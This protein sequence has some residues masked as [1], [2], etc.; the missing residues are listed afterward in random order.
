MK[1]WIGHILEEPE[2]WFLVWAETEA[3]ALLMVD[4]TYGEPDVRSLLEIDLPGCLSLLVEQTEEF[5]GESTDLLIPNCDDEL[6]ME[7]SNKPSVEDWITY[8]LNH[9]FGPAKKVDMSYIA[10]QM[11]IVQPEVLEAY[12]FKKCPKCE[13]KDYSEKKGCLRC[14]YSE[15]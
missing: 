15:Q 8:C 13:S 2:N 12:N 6:V 7:R 4:S 9:P 5:E 10:Q 1:L 3:E 14:G 11:R